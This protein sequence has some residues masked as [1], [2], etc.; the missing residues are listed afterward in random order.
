MKM[1]SVR[2]ALLL[3]VAFA[4]ANLSWP[5][6]KSLNSPYKF[7]EVQDKAGVHFQFRNS[8]TPNK[9]LIETMGGGVAI[10]DYDND[11]W[12]DIFFV[13]G[14]RL[15]NPQS[16]SEPLDKSAPEYWNRLFRNNHDGTFQDVTEK[17]GVQG[18]GYG[19]GVA[20][21][22][23]DN[24]GFPDLI[25]T[26]YGGCILYHNNGDGTFTDVTARSGIKA[27]GWNM[28]AGFLDYD[29]DGRLDLFVTRYLE[30]NFSIGGKKCGVNVTGGRAY[31]HPNEFRAIS[32]YLFH[33]NGDGTFTDV[34]DRSGIAASKGYGLGSAFGDY[35]ND[36]LMDIYVANDAFP[37]FL[38]KN[39]G[40][41]TFS[42]VAAFAGV[43][44]TE[45][46]STFSGMGTD[47][48]DLDND[49]WPD[50]VTTALPYEYF[51]L[52]HNSG[53]GTFGYTSVT[54]NLAEI[55]RPYGGWGIHVFDCDND[56]TNELFV[57]TS[58]VMDNIGVT[59]PHLHYLEKPLLLKYAANRFTD[60][61]AEAGEA[62]QHPWAARGAAFGDLFN[63]G[64]I[65]MV[66]SDYAGP[67][68]LL[69]NESGI[70]NHWI[71]LTLQGTKSNRDGIGARV[72]LVSGAGKVQH[73]SVSTAG[74][75]AS[76]NDRRV[77]FGLGGETTIREIDIRWPS[78][79]EQR[80]NDPKPGHILPVVEAGEAISPPR[81]NSSVPHIPF[82]SPASARGL[83]SSFKTVSFAAAPPVQNEYQN[84]LALLRQ[85]RLNEAVEHL[86]AAV[87]LNPDSVDAHYAFGVALSR[88]GR[89]HLPAALDQFL[90]VLRLKPDN[91]DAR[92]DLS[93][94]L[95]LE[96]DSAA[97]AS[98]LE[99]AIRIAPANTDL[100][101]LLGKA[102]LDSNEFSWAT[103]SFQKAL[104][105]N[106]RLAA[107]HYG[108][109]LTAAKQRDSARAIQEFQKA[110]ELNPSDA[111][112][113]WNWGGFTFR[114][115]IWTRPPWI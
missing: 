56:G 104:E 109:G 21:G 36:G 39:N 90:E 28:S 91:V 68:H 9:Y 82:S 48:V 6:S 80:I 65:D 103:Q 79:I 22:D 41:G 1:R 60:I 63:D 25:V 94:V 112:S 73:R 20:V 87:R 24:D 97:A 57:A 53:D 8:A 70:S 51:A 50:I 78:G 11:G 76:A 115:A 111:F 29:N 75:Y 83:C 17:A 62:F 105:L 64:R 88:M 92:V 16:D 86:E 69:R 84:G 37:Q 31:C 74:S 54:T 47:F 100:Y 33:N 19:M 26:N 101:I 38:F 110:I 4:M 67:A 12:P 43:G 99:Q 113:T 108:L 61:S 10:F 81:A 93:S 23:Y 95:A 2:L 14:A 44:Y 77:A 7:V 55:S 59:Q 114:Q 13:N 107:A 98:Q 52:F 32:N 89:D 49:G 58:H 45:D 96:G 106:S 3:I 102:Q 71:E 85:G 35:N 15:N 5:A 42:E 72:K 27:D 30:W 46:G 18:R 66:I 40:N 34:S